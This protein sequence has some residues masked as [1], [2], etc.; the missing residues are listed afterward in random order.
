MRWNRADARPQAARHRRQLVKWLKLCGLAVLGIC[1]VSIPLTVAIVLSTTGASDVLT[2][3]G[4][5]PKHQH[6]TPA[7]AIADIRCVPK[8]GYY[9]LTFDQGPFAGTTGKLVAALVKARAVATF[10]DVGEQAAAHQDL[11]E[12]QRTVGQVAN[13]AYSAPDLTAVSQARR[14]QELQAT[15]KVLDYPN[16]LFRPPYGVTNPSVE[17]DVHHTGLTTVYWTVDA[18]AGDLS[19]TAVVQLALQVRPGGIIRL[20]DGREAPLQAIPAVVSGLRRL[21]MCPGLIAPTR[22]NVIGANGLIFHAV[23]VKP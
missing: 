12:L 11:V 23:A 9:A 14:Y 3:G 5:S 16:I 13:E 2:L 18:S 8:R 21:G 1:T 20:K 4:I 17:G 7:G 6:E 10:F 19:A 22:Q 15:A